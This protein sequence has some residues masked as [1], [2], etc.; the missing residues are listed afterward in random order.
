MNNK[1]NE[2][3]FIDHT[4]SNLKKEEEK[5]LENLNGKSMFNLNSLIGKFEQKNE[6]EYDDEPDKQIINIDDD[7]NI[8][9][10]DDKILQKDNNNNKCPILSYIISKICH[11]ILLNRMKSMLKSISC[12]YNDLCIKWN[13]LNSA[14]M[15]NV[16]I[17]RKNKLLLNITLKGMKIN[18]IKYNL[19]CSKSIHCFNI[20]QLSDLVGT[21]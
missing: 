17:E 21:L 6:N 11:I 16:N 7:N 15:V 13:Q 10:N 3:L 5:Y 12:K 1:Y 20:K 14:S 9:N 18:L 8:N 2:S 4:F 19:K